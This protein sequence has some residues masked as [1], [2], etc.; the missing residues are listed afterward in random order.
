M[1]LLGG[2]AAE[3]IDGLA[4]RIRVRL[5][6]KGILTLAEVEV[7]SGGKNIARQGKASQTSTGY[8]GVAQ[9]AIDGNT[10]GLEKNKS[11]SHSSGKDVPSWEVML[12]RPSAIE[13]IV[14]HNRTENGL[15]ARLSGALVEVLDG[16]GEVLW[17]GEVD[18]PAKARH[19]FAVTV[20]PM[21]RLLAT[22]PSSWTPEE[23]NQ[24]LA[25]YTAS[26]DQGVSNAE[27]ELARARAAVKKHEANFTKTMVMK[28]METP[29]TTYVLNRGL[30][31]QP[32]KDRVVTPRPPEAIDLPLDG[33]AANRLGLAQWLV[34]PDHPLTA[35]VTVNRMWQ[36]YFGVGLVETSEDFGVQGEWPSHPGL[37][38]WLS[39]DFID[40]GWDMKQL[41][42]QMVLSST[43]R[44]AAITTA[45]KLEKDPFNRLLSRGP[46]FRMRAQLVR[47]QALAASGLL[48]PKVGGPSVKPY[49]PPGLWAEVSFASK[50]RD[51]DFYT[52]DTGEKLYRRG[53]Y[54]F[55]KRTLN[56]PGMAAFD[57]AS[58]EYCVV[59]VPRTNS[60]LQALNMMNDPTYL[61]ASR[62]L[63]ERM[64]KEGGADPGKRIAFGYETVLVES[65]PK[66]TARRLAKGLADY[67]AALAADPEAVD[68]LLAAGESPVDATLNREELA[69][70]SLL[71]SVLLNLDG[72]VT[73]P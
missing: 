39:R 27:A 20:T 4:S 25:F 55:W 24:V 37:L 7:F 53:L 54:T 43:Y 10:A 58:R 32:D 72:A 69:A 36:E 21:K 6:K 16:E 38:D 42:K 12:K 68:G 63:A 41:V 40:S 49:Q 62:K 73:R 28:E 3:A 14:V 2:G 47:D 60:P 30:Y 34:H 22:K 46:R 65:I 1:S 23:R 9:R 48:V 66:E 59:R 67:R 64:M 18:T 57:A 51:T 19:E 45:E 29:R 70:Y 35:R 61:E 8:G 17:S 52:Q 71:A 26:F 31:D 5:P 11:L 33:F 15:E 44:Q 50:T 13:R 56:P